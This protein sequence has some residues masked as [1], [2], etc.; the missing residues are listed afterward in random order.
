MTLYT[1]DGNGREDILPKLYLLVKFGFPVL[2]I[3]PKFTEV[4]KELVESY[5]ELCWL[6]TGT[7]VHEME[8]DTSNCAFQILH[9]AHQL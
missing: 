7:S 6:Q 5:L 8:A 3:I 9:R 4:V 2:E 1:C